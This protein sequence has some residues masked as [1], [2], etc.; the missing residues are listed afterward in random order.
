MNFFGLVFLCVMVFGGS[1]IDASTSSSDSSSTTSAA[2]DAPSSSKLTPLDDDIATLG[3]KI[4]DLTGKVASKKTDVAAFQAKLDS[5]DKQRSD[6]KNV[7]AV[8][9]TLGDDQSSTLDT[10]YASAKADFDKATADLTLLNDR[11]ADLTSR[12]AVES[13]LKKKVSDMDTFMN[14]SMAAD[15]DAAD[16]AILLAPVD[17]SGL[18]GASTDKATNTDK[19]TAAAKSGS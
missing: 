17:F 15:A 4:V 5:L 11:L 7:G 8:G 13:F 19:T 18:A 1:A 16:L 3:Q 6:A 14:A 9:K 12:Q 2:G 10:Q